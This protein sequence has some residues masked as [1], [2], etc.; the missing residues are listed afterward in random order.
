MK[1]FDPF[2]CRKLISGTMHYVAPIPIILGVVGA[3]A[4]LVWLVAAGSDDDG[5]PDSGMFFLFGALYIGI[6]VLKALFNEPMSVL[7][8]FGILILSAGL[9]WAGIVML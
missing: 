3:I 7:P 8:A 2:A 4:G 9:I 1:F 5:G 6:R